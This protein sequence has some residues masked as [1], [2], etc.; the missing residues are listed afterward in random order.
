MGPTLPALDPA[1]A[2]RLIGQ[3]PAGRVL[4]IGDVMLDRFLVGRVS[5]ISP[6]A[7]V[8]VVVYDH[9]DYRLGGAA[10]V[11]HNIAAL[12]GHATLV[13]VV[14]EDDD[15]AAV[16]GHDGRRASTSGLVTVPDRRTTPRPA[17]SRRATSRW[18]A[19]TTRRTRTSGPRPRTPSWRWWTDTDGA[20]ALLVSDYQK[21]VVT[22]RVMAHLVAR[23][24]DAGIPLLVDPKVPHLDF[25]RGATLVTPNQM[26]AE[27]AAGRRIRTV[28]DAREV[29]RSLLSRAGVEG[30]L[31]TLGERGM[32]LSHADGEGSLAAAARE[33]SDVTGAGDTVIATLALA[34]A[35]GAGIA[36]AAGLANVAAGIVVG[37]FGAATV[38]A[39]ELSHE[40]HEGHGGHEGHEE[41]G[42]RNG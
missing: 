25:Y 35:A 34:M 14:G 20:G 16:G 28:D 18:P 32:W 42:G 17:S 1:R 39:A 29:A 37:R 6:E 30:V 41:H 13:G 12:G 10:N 7:P 19:S 3:F 27:A 9:D 5:R 40:V 24:T 2:T 33:V 36:E 21:G 31:V 8:P 38:S 26:E 22:R 4:V 11:A 23:S 15:V